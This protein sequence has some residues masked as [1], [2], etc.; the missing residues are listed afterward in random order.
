MHPP[1][2]MYFFRI[3]MQCKAFLEN[4]CLI[5]DLEGYCVQK[6]FYARELGWTTWQGQ[7][8]AKHYQLP[9][10]WKTLCPKDRLTA[11]YV[12]HRIH[13]LPFEAHTA[14]KARPLKNLKGDVLT[15]YTQ[16]KTPE[17]FVV[18]YKGGH[19]EK[20]LLQELDLPAMNLEEYGC[21]KFEKLDTLSVIQ[22]CGHHR[23][24]HHCAMVESHAFWQWANRADEE[25]D[26]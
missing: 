5:L 13:G 21:P 8:G 26:T 24:K 25:K 11:Q 10:R 6:K 18:G 2:D 4:V 16:A 19:I 12:Y 23:F 14:E 7:S 9:F 15:L 3:R 17:R 1:F 22:D 20:D